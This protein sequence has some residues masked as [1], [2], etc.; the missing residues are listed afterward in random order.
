[1]CIRDRA[2]TLRLRLDQ[3][4]AD[5]ADGLLDGRQLHLATS[6]TGAKLAAVELA[7]ADAGRGSRLAPL[8]AAA[9]PGQ[10]WLAADLPTRQ[11]VLDT[12]A[13]VT[14]LPGAPGRA[15]FDPASVRVEWRM[16]P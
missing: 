1:M 13:T 5:Y 15:P 11:A 3:Q 16:Q 7:L 10:A 12:L 14:V 9:D 8:L 4:A 6:R 2:A